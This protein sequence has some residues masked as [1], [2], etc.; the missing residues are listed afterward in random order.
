MR[1]AQRTWH[2]PEEIIAKFRPC[3]E[4][5]LLAARWR[6]HDNH[7][8]FHRAFGKLTPAAFAA[9]HSAPSTGFGHLT[10][11]NRQTTANTRAPQ[12]IAGASNHLS[13]NA[14]P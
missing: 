6:L 10:R 2:R 8:R 12:L 1:S 3:D 7:R 9:M 11:E 14:M 4:A 13:R 5:R